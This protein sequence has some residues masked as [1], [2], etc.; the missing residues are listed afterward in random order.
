MFG[1]SFHKPLQYIFKNN[2]QQN[3]EYLIENN[4]ITENQSGFKP[5]DFCINQSILSITR[6]YKS[7]DNSFEV[8]GA[9]LNISKEFDK[10]LIFK[11]KQ[12]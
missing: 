9:F 5:G 6:L 2:L 4:L 8:K 11:L 1:E 3:F 7:F 12:N 10:G